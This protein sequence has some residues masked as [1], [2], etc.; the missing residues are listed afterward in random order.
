MSRSFTKENKV[1]RFSFLILCFLLLSTGTS[2]AQKQTKKDLENKK[3]QIQKEIDYTNQLLA[4]TKKNKKRSLTELVALNKKISQ[5]EELILNI[6]SQISLLDQQI[7]DNNES[8]NHL[9]TDLAKLKAEYAKMIYYA[10]KNQDAYNRLVFIFAAKD[11]EQA[12]MRLKYLQQ[13]SDYRHQ[14][15]EKIMNTKKSLNEKVQD[16]ET[17]KSDKRTLLTG[18][19]SEKLNLTSE[20]GEKEQ[21]FSQLQD[22][23]GKLKKDLDKKKKDASNL[24]QAIQ[25]IIQKELEKAQKE[26]AEQ[27]NNNKNPDKSAPKD[28]KPKKLIL[29]PETQQLSNSF[30]SNK[31]KLPWPVAKGIIYEHYGVHPHP[32]IPNI[33]IT[34]NGLDIAT[35]TGSIAR[36]VFDGEVKG[37]VSMPGAGQ[38]VLVRHGE[39]LTVYANLK[40]VYVKVGDKLTTKQS[41]GSIQY[42]DDDNKTVLHFEIWKGTTKLDPEDWIFKSN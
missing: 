8:I 38:F 9:Q 42:D 23:E 40:D 41:I 27:Q 20:K 33:D 19:E 13:Y 24:E 5:R 26:Y 25:R 1:M 4:E 30:A 18:E 36:V 31:A 32:L 2:F 15:A 29:T 21:V 16:L 3:K 7:K 37:V 14:Q 39:F 35:N 22:Q 34:N 10:Y 12:Y 11:F 17:K 6:N 28:N